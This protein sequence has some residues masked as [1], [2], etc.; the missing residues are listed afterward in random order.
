MIEITNGKKTLTV[1][2][3]TAQATLK[4]K[5]LK[6]WTI[7]KPVGNAPQEVIQFQQAKLKESCTVKEIPEPKSEDDLFKLPLSKLEGIADTLSED[8][9]KNLIQDPRK[10]VKALAKRQ[11]NKLRSDSRK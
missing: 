4:E 1:P 9:L 2:D 11:L 6:G 7:V 10:N 5:W 3:A 8:Q